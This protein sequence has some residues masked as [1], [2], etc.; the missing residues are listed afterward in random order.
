MKRTVLLL[1]IV[2]TL[3]GVATA[4]TTSYFPQIA[5]GS[6][7]GAF[8]TTTIFVAN[9]AESGSIN[10]T[11]TFTKSDGDPF[12]IAFVDEDG[13]SVGS[14]NT[15]TI[16]ALAAGQSRK[17]ISTAASPIAIG[18]ATITSDGSVSTSAIY[19]QFS[20]IPGSGTLFSEAAVTPTDTSLSQAIFIDESGTFRTALALANPSIAATTVTLSLLNIEAQQVLTTPVPLL[21]NN[22]F[23]RFVDEIFAPTSIDGHVGTLQIVSDAALASVALRFAGDLFTSIPPF[24]LASLSLPINAWSR[25]VDTWLESRPWLSPLASFARLIGSLRPLG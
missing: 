13:Q 10:V 6:F 3:S 9:P 16:A 15:L 7:T 25:P 12:N 4:Q 5:D 8:F 23:G 17:V 18:Y 22:H 2:A 24:S 11:F 1:V 19:S 20:G 21:A 14:G